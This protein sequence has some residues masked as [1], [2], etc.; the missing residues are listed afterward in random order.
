MTTATESAPTIIRRRRVEGKVSL[1]RS[2]I[3]ERIAAGTF[4]APVKLGARAV[5]WIESEVD[6]WIRERVNESRK[7]AA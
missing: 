6:D 2:T 7:A 1:S 3:Y 5:G 4:P